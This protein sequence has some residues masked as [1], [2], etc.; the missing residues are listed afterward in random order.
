MSLDELFF[1]L[2][3]VTSTIRYGMD[4]ESGKTVQATRRIYFFGICIIAYDIFLP[5]L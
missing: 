1:L 3:P 5:D 2:R 4:R